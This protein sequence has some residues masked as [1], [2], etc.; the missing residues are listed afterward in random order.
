[1][2]PELW[3]DIQGNVE[4]MDDLYDATFYTWLKSEDN[5]LVTA[6]YLQRLAS[7][8]DLDRIEH[9]LCWLVNQWQLESI[10]VLVK[11]VTFDWVVTKGDQG[12]L[13]RAKLI[14]AITDN[15]GIQ[16]IARLACILLT[17]ATASSSPQL[18]P[19]FKFS[20][21]HSRM[22]SLPGSP[23]ISHNTSPTT[24]SSMFG[25]HGQT[26]GHSLTSSSTSSSSLSRPST[27]PPSSHS[28][29]ST[30]SAT[31][32]S[33]SSPSPSFSSTST[34]Q[35]TQGRRMAVSRRL[36]SPMAMST[37]TNAA[38][39]AIR[40]LGRTS[41][42]V[43]QSGFS[44]G[45]HHRQTSSILPVQHQRQQDHTQ[46]GATASS[47]S[48]LDSSSTPTSATSIAPGYS[49]HIHPH[50]CNL[51]HHQHHHHQ[52]QQ[53]PSQQQQQPQHLPRNISHIANITRGVGTHSR[54][55]SQPGTVSASK[56][57]W[58]QQQSAYS[59]NPVFYMNKSLFM[60]E[61]SKKWSFCRLSE[62]FQHMDPASGISHRFKCKLLKESALKEEKSQK[63]SA[64]SGSKRDQ[65]TKQQIHEEQS[66]PSE[67]NSREEQSKADG[68]VIVSPIDPNQ[69]DSDEGAMDISVDV[70]MMENDETPSTTSQMSTA[71]HVVRR[72]HDP[73]LLHP[74]DSAISSSSTTINST[75]NG[76]T[77]TPINVSQHEQ[78]QYHS[79]QNYTHGDYNDDM[80]SGLS[81]GCKPA[82]NSHQHCRSQTVNATMCSG[83]GIT[84]TIL[85]SSS[86]S[87]SSSASSPTS[88]AAASASLS[89]L[90]L[91]ESGM[92][93][94]SKPL[95]QPQSHQHQS[96]LPPYNSSFSSPGLY[97]H[98]TAHSA[99]AS[100]PSVPN[101]S[102]SVATP[103]STTTLSIH[104]NTSQR[105]THDSTSTK[106]KNSLG[107]SLTPQSHCSSF[108][109][110]S[111]SSATAHS[112]ADASMPSS[113][114]IFPGAR[115][116]STSTSTT[117]EDLK[118][119][120]CSRQN[121]TTSTSGI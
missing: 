116:T 41:S 25:P 108:S 7:E 53:S 15:W 103:S 88:T 18:M 27:P 14:L 115:R 48:P 101:S 66:K 38:S 95:S 13:D 86:S 75:R 85:T 2:D 67:S 49:S 64:T 76:P 121:S 56:Q 79:I 50:Q 65:T 54:Q 81:R 51:P 89:T 32:S 68:S 4:K 120:R 45:G 33:P 19:V 9:A 36:G 91:T 94:S 52:R 17:G 5:V 37:I 78:T 118:R 31:S 82:E 59:S 111:S 96:S 63:Q 23:M 80:N 40:H 97:R 100:S 109:S 21:C 72:I 20:P 6:S 12:E 60:E 74:F 58:L 44:R 35:S 34:H 105:H 92:E 102:T 39:D 87:C 57:H 28:P 11:Q 43:S 70:E 119:L 114:S 112:S 10:A 46:Q 62:F 84:G 117:N 98:A 42:T 47:T 106:R 55:Q 83:L 113:S 8:Y 16:Y 90:T 3:K 104:A 22:S 73:D 1:M 26:Y 93:P 77:S 69:L 71:A 99:T 30:R 24:N 29:L 61:L 107:V 110:T